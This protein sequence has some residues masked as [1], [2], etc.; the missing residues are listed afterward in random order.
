MIQN[1]WEWPKD[2]WS[3]LRHMSWKGVHAWYCPDGQQPDA[4]YSET[5]DRTKHVW[6]GNRVNKMIPNNILL[7][8]D[9][10]LAQLSS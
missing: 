6:E 3:N 5:G 4:E 1:S 9:Q 2:E 7:Q 10:C 8:S